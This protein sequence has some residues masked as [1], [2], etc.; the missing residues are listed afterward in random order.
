[1]ITARFYSS[2]HLG[3]EDEERGYDVDDRISGKD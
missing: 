1:M 3:I 2:D